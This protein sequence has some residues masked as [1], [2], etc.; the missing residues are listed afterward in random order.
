MD[1]PSSVKII[2]HR[3]VLGQVDLRWPSSQVI[4]NCQFKINIKTCTRSGLG[5][6]T[7]TSEVAEVIALSDRPGLTLCGH[8]RKAALI[9]ALTLRYLMFCIRYILSAEQ[10]NSQFIKY[11]L[12]VLCRF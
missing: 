1:L 12:Y 10:M 3:H 8:F 2:L 6:A 5:L 7:L 11:I 4:L 9:S